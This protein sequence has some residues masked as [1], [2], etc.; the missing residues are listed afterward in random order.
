MGRGAELGEPPAL[1]AGEPLADGVDL[2]DVRAAGQH[3]AGDVLQLRQ[4]Y[5][6]RSNRQSRLRTPETARGPLR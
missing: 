5:Q 4:R 1:D 3:L 2:G 6:R